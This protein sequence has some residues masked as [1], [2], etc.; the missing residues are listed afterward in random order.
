MDYEGKCKH[1]HGHNGVVEI[2]LQSDKLDKRGMVY[3]FDDLKSRIQ[4]WIDEKLDHKMLLRRDDPLA[5]TLISIGEPLYLMDENPSAE[6]IARHIFEFAYS[7]GMPVVEVRVWETDSS[8]ASYSR[9][10]A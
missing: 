5:K 3:D 7:Q 4:G 2:T 10:V 1:P 6:A 9:V 8:V